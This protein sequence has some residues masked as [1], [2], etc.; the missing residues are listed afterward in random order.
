MNAEGNA[1][2]IL[3]EIETVPEYITR[4]PDEFFLPE[5]AKNRSVRNGLH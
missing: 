5:K 2:M 1:F 4:E 3:N